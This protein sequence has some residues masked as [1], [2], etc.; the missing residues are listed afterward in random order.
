MH[1]SVQSLPFAR[2]PLQ[3]KPRK[4]RFRPHVELVIVAENVEDRDIWAHDIRLL[5]APYQ[6]LERRMYE[7]REL[8]PRQL[9]PDQLRLLAFNI[10]KRKIHVLLEAA[11]T[12]R[13]LS[14]YTLP[15]L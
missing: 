5:I 1:D 14:A 13:I 6:L 12:A 7:F 3:V 8:L 4:F 10:N 11:K 2:I 9:G 15:S